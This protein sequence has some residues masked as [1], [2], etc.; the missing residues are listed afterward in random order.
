M[1]TP[2]DGGPWL[3]YMELPAHMGLNTTLAALRM[4]F[5]RKFP[6]LES[7][8]KIG[9]Q[10][11]NDLQTPKRSKK[12]ICDRTIRGH[13]TYAVR[14]RAIVGGVWVKC[15]RVVYTDV[16]GLICKMFKAVAST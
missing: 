10:E 13:P 5:C 15:L 8:P 6:F 1:K 4:R 11:F 14:H 7:N 3:N 16:N 9:Y 2:Q 12:Q